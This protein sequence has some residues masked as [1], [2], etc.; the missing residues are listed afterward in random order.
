MAIDTA[1][2]MIN[3]V[4]DGNLVENFTIAVLK[5]SKENIN[6]KGN[7]ILG[8]TQLS[9]KFWRVFS[10]KLTNHNIFSDFPPLSIMEKRTNGDE[11]CLEEGV[12]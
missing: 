7:I 9:S 4:V 10:N 3:W 11:I 8:A 2:A 5:D 1:S 6:L 12:R